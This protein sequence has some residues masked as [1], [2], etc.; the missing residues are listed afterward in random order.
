MDRNRDEKFEFGDNLRID[1]TSKKVKKAVRYVLKGFV[2]ANLYV[3]GEQYRSCS[4]ISSIV[5]M[6]RTFGKRNINDADSR[7]FGRSPEAKDVWRKNF[8]VVIRAH[9]RI[10]TCE[11]VANLTG[12]ERTNL[13]AAKA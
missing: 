6:L 2:F 4:G 12:C 13:T 1:R 9:N 5:A 8:G 3:V 7:S 11:G 10:N